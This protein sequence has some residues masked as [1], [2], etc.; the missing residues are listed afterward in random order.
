MERQQPRIITKAM[1]MLAVT[2]CIA[3]TW[4]LPGPA[5]QPFTRGEVLFMAWTGVLTLVAAYL[6]CQ[7]LMGC[8]R[9]RE[10]STVFRL[11]MRV[12]RL[13]GR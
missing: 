13:L 5:Q 2:T 1:V 4:M 3:L 12:G 10:A 8:R 9:V 6:L 7:D 11:G